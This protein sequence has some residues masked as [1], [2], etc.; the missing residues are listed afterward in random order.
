LE[1]LVDHKLADFEGFFAPLA[2]VL[3]AFGE[4]HNLRIEKYHRGQPNW[5]F[6]FRIGEL[7]RGHLQV[8]GS[9]PSEVLI[10]G[11]R[12]QRDF[13]RY[14]RFIGQVGAVR[15]PMD[16]PQFAQ[17]LG[18]VL[19]EIVDLP[20]SELRTDGFDWSHG[21]GSSRAHAST[22]RRSHA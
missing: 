15:V 8:L 3:V 22:S 2:S 11:G 21:S 5:S 7:G 12:E 9:G 1:D 17:E 19:L 20:T 10:A 14:L 18:E 4:R 6:H 16:C 13:E